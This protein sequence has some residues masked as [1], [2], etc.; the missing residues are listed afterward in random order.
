M[1]AFASEPADG[2]LERARSDGEGAGKGALERADAATAGPAGGGLQDSRGQLLGWQGD[3]GEGAAATKRALA[4]SL[5]G[6]GVRRPGALAFCNGE[7]EGQ[8]ERK[9]T[10]E[11]LA[12]DAVLYTGEEVWVGRAR[13]WGGRRQSS[14]PHPHPPAPA[15]APP[16]AMWALAPPPLN[17][18]TFP[19]LPPHQATPSS[20]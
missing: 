4:A 3:R 1:P 16:P 18:H 11:D 20:T 9:R 7:L 2:T 15:L 6:A 17:T 8:W 5:A 12:A 10:H 19:T 14:R 13:A